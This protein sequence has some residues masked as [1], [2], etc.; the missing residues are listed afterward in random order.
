MQSPPPP[1]LYKPLPIIPL[2]KNIYVPVA[3]VAVA[4]MLAGCAGGSG[5]MAAT[6]K[7]CGTDMACMSASAEKCE[8]A[9]GTLEQNSGGVGMNM[10]IQIQGGTVDACTTYYKIDSILYPEGTTAQQKA[11]MDQM[12]KGKDMTC[13][14]PH[15]VQMEEAIALDKCTGT[16]VDVM[17]MATNSYS[18]TGST[19]D[20][21]NPNDYGGYGSGL[22]VY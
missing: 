20:S 21:G 8:Q 9:Y 12:L 14:M 10:Y 22:P 16:L 2:M 5:T 13:T 15:N 3:L 6:G 4:I 17:K 11:V 19:G 18:D 7:N 1:N